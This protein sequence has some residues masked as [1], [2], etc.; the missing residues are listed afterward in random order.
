MV[1][2]TPV[3]RP[4]GQLRGIVPVPA[5][6]DEVMVTGISLD[7]RQI[8][9]GDI[10]AA[11]AG[12]HHHGATFAPEAV[13]AG[14][15]AILTDAQGQQLAAELGV[16]VLVAADPRGLLGAVSAWVYGKPSEGMTL[17]GVTG[18]DGKT[19]TTMF[20]EAALRGCGHS[21]GLIGT[22]VTR[23]DGEELPSIRTT[24]EAPDL[25]ALLAVM[26]E[27]GV[28]HVAMEVS[29]HALALGRV[30]A[31]AFDVAIFTNLGHDHLDFHG[32][33]QHYFEAKAALFTP[34]H[35]RQAL[36]CIDDERGRELA[37]RAA[38]STAT[39]SVT[40][41]TQT[42]TAGSAD[43][44][45][46]HLAGS[47]VGWSYELTYDAGEVAAGTSVPGVFNVR[48]AVAATAAA[49]M[50]GC[51]IDTV[52]RSVREYPGAPG[53]MESVNAGQPF[54]VLVDYAH[55]PDAVERALLVGR[56]TATRTDGRLL[57]LLGCGGD[58]DRA[59]RPKMGA[60][61]VRLADVI[62]ITD[63][64]P[65]SEDPA[66]IRREILAGAWA[67]AGGPVGTVVEQAGREA[68]LHELVSLAEPGDVVM[69]LGKGH[70][71]GQ[72]IAGVVHPLDDRAVLRAALTEGPR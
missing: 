8:I 42:Q 13:A 67:V 20:L 3:A 32:D 59:K 15:I 7:S 60:T 43:W 57:V 2:P 68:A 38:V 17:I 49:V 70:E 1:R 63:D 52:V 10:Y 66:A 5:E 35:S 51:P 16:P 44:Q 21:T 45:A 47:G 53:R 37:A 9:P 6:F 56:E 48:N 12:E 23:L 19:T 65:R 14:A 36:V 11:L 69:A 28:T 34:G 25:Q 72:E 4:L 50:V 29:S 71:V 55:T 33:Q 26:R 46:G 31:I 27:R 64:N 61:A 40:E 62:L 41:P 30:N 54:A 58:R 39:Y 24:P 18:T 22:I